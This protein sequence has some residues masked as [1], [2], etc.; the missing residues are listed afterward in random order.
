MCKARLKT[1]LL[2]FAVFA[3]EQAVMQWMLWLFQLPELKTQVV[4]GT[5]VVSAISFPLTWPMWRTDKEYYGPMPEEC[6]DDTALIDHTK[7]RLH[8]AVLFASAL[9]VIT[10][11]T[12]LIQWFLASW[13]YSVLFAWDACIICITWDSI[14]LLYTSPSPRDRTRSRMPSSA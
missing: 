6:R 2:V 5:M 11:A 3:A 13:F 9:F 8:R 4:I 10:I 14:C 12:F 1:V 7:G